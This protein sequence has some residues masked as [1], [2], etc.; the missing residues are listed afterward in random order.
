MMTMPVNML[1]QGAKHCALAPG[2][3]SC[4]IFL[5]YINFKKRIDKK[6]SRRYNANKRSHMG[7]LRM[8][9]QNHQTWQERERKALVYRGWLVQARLSARMTQLEVA[10]A[11]G[12][13]RSAYQKYEYGQRTPRKSKREELQKVLALCLSGFDKAQEEQ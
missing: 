8:M 9:Q 3:D 1:I 2:C 10:D 4:F 11:C 13:S 5:Q 12:I 7:D 6:I